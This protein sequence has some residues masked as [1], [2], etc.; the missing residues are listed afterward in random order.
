MQ[1][2]RG[3]DKNP[4]KFRDSQNWIGSPG[5]T[6]EEATYV[7]PPPLA[8]NDLLE[9]FITFTNINDGTLDPIVQT[10]LM[11]AQFELIH[12]FDDGNG[13]IGRLLIPLLLTQ[14]GSIV[15]PSFYISRYFEL[16]R[17]IYYARLEGI[18]RHGDWIGWIEF[19]LNAVVSQSENNVLL[20][21]KVIEL[22]ET[23]KKEITKLLRTD[24]GI[25]ILDLLFDTPVFQ[26]STVHE[27][28]NIQRQRAAAY[29]RTLK[30]AGIIREVRP[31][32]GRRPS[33]YSFEPLWKITDQ[34]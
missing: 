28:L 12:P 7:P 19:F 25:Y 9:K 21:R 29:L 31:A 10:A 22:Y 30:D 15:S 17:D 32:S 24:Q 20:V 14:R 4:G 33:V 16:H 27:R 6:I 11:H 1:G 18:S 23:T 13:R 3:K 2:V 34:Q 8:L 5:C 26:G